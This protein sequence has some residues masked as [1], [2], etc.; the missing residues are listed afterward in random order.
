M[1]IGLQAFL[2]C[3][4]SNQTILMVIQRTLLPLNALLALMEPIGLF[5][6]AL[7]LVAFVV[8]KL[9]YQARHLA[10]DSVPKF[11]PRQVFTLIMLLFLPVPCLSCL[12][13]AL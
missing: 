9:H 2:F 6:S 5:L 1:V 4:L 8:A 12:H 3:W 11:F 7:S 10:V 13:F